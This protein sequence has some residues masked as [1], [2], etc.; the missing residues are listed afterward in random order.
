MRKSL[1]ALFILIP[2]C[3]AVAD[4]VELRQQYKSGYRYLQAV[5]ITQE[6]SVSTGVSNSTSKSSTTLDL[7]TIAQPV[8]VDGGKGTSL[9]VRYAK[10]AM[11]LERD[12][13]TFR[14]P[15][16]PVE[17]ESAI[18]NPNAQAGPLLALAAIPGRTFTVNLNEQGAVESVQN[19]EV[20]V[21]TLAGSGPLTNATFREM[22]T[23]DAIARMFSQTMLRTPKGQ[24]PKNGDSWPLAQEIVLPGLGA[25]VVSGSYKLVG[26][27]D[28]EGAQCADIEVSA[29]ISKRPPAR[30]IQDL[31]DNDRF[32][33]LSRQ[34]R[35]KLDG[36]TM[37]GRILFDPA[38][39]FPRSISITQT[40]A[41]EA[42]IPD[43]TKNVIKMPV[44]QT[45]SV[46]L[47]EMTNVHPE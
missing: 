12:G 25:L 45:T 47:V 27:L 33:T 8:D 37:T 31:Q 23:G 10:V 13:R 11:T 20:A 24:L 21:A 14:Y 44:K 6:S 29:T 15:I 4:G 26:T 3:W 35:L 18:A 36:S 39:S 28:Y 42:K 7:E 22:F 41:I 38:I 9:A 1:S 34:M 46:K 17:G 5:N 43:G 32:D 40:L 19:P 2:S 30:E 16:E